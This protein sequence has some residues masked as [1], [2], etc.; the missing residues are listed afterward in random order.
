MRDVR[1]FDAFLPDPE[2]YRRAALEH[3]YRSYDFPEVNVTFH[4]IALPAGAEVPLKL[5]RMFPGATPTLSFFRR[6]P[7]GQEEPH[8][9]HTDIDMGEWTALLYLNPDPPAGDGTDFWRYLPTG[10][11]ENE[12]PHLRS[13]E[14]MTPDPA[15]WA[16]WRRVSAKFNRLV[17]FPATYL[18]S[19]ALFDNWGADADARLT[20]VTFGKG[21]I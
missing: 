18:H 3:E 7:A 21:A 2:S 1:V 9:I 6:S 20:Q 14:G 19:R 4:G 11:I 16:R 17:L 13:S 10:E 15:L 12:T 8:F 5:V